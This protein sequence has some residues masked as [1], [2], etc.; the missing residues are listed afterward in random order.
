MPKASRFVLSA[1]SICG[2]TIQTVHLLSRVRTVRR[3]CVHAT[4]VSYVSLSRAE[5]PVRN[6]S[7]WIMVCETSDAV[8]WVPI[9]S[10]MRQGEDLYAGCMVAMAELLLSGCTTA[11][12][13]H[14]FYT[15]GM[16]CVNSVTS[17]RAIIQPAAALAVVLFED[18][19]VPIT[20]RP[21]LPIEKSLRDLSTVP[22]SH[23][24][25]AVVSRLTERHTLYAIIDSSACF[26]TA[27]TAPAVFGPSHLMC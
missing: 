9:V 21:L 16:M 4:F 12:D 14:Y 17:T 2:P 22:V 13:H 11:S 26:A 18:G 6:C 20:C 19:R 25:L 5:L 1:C 8:C 15:N 3:G 27:D 7:R 24:G 23:H 10:T